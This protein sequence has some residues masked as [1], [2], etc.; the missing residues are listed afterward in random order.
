MFSHSLIRNIDKNIYK[1]KGKTSKESLAIIDGTYFNNNKYIQQIHIN[2][3][4]SY[5]LRYSDNPPHPIEKL[6]F[7]YIKSAN[8]IDLISDEYNYPIC[9]YTLIKTGYTFD[10][11]SMECIKDLKLEYL[12]SINEKKITSKTILYLY[13][14]GNCD[15][16]EYFKNLNIQY[17]N[18]DY[19]KLILCIQSI[20]RYSYIQTSD[21]HINRILKK[22][23]KIN[24][25][26]FV[27]LIEKLIKKNYIS[28][29][30]SIIYRLLSIL[31]CN[32]NTLFTKMFI[33]LLDKH[34][35]SIINGWNLLYTIRLKEINDKTTGYVTIEYINYLISE[36][37][38]YYYENVTMD[39]N[40]NIMNIPMQKNIFC[41]F[42]YKYIKSNWKGDILEDF[43]N[44][45][46]IVINEDNIK[47]CY[48][49]PDI[50]EW[51]NIIPTMETLCAILK[52]NNC[53]VKKPYKR[54]QKAVL[55]LVDKYGF[56][57]KEI[58]DE[59]VQYNCPY[60]INEILSRKITPDINTISKYS[61]PSNIMTLLI[62][63]GIYID[64][65]VIKK[66]SLTGTLLEPT[67]Y[68]EKSLTEEIYYNF[69]KTNTTIPEEYYFVFDIP[70]KLLELR[71]ISNSNKLQTI[72]K[73]AKKY[74]LQIDMYC[75]NNMVKNS[76][77]RSINFY[78]KFV[79]K[80]KE[81][82]IPLLIS[83]NEFIKKNLQSHIDVCNGW[84]DMI[85]LIPLKA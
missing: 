34:K 52:I 20:S 64:D 60:L 61:I 2:D 47:N 1:Y 55:Y 53:R 28:G 46:F 7:H 85:K 59:T 83:D 54:P 38:R 24:E 23:D 22:I 14:R 70:Y 73:Y 35:F 81:F 31:T 77:T 9:V 48:L 71:N 13:K 43:C 11:E 58:L 33:N 36:N 18:S 79:D 37:L 12:F 42:N 19:L 17:S 74:N 66:L 51:L 44:K 41:K 80:S 75:F 69:Y 30:L 67:F 78:N 5:I 21:Y 25:S 32:D 40:N 63:Y 39:K 10:Q 82:K 8:V 57:L 16:Y 50:F 62:N 15:W 65:D 26:E 27:F 76:P 49:N 29:D 45:W 4:V 3:Y 6:V 84:E 56:N 72:I 68:K